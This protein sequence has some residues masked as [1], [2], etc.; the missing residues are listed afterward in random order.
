M[1]QTMSPITYVQLKDRKR[2]NYESVLENATTANLDSF[3]IITSAAEHHSIVDN[4][5]VILGY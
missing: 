1:Q 2:V 4:C 3:I 5:G